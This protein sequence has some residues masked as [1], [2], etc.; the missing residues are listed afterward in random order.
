M[1]ASNGIHPERVIRGGHSTTSNPPSEDG[2]ETQPSE[3]GGPSDAIVQRLA[4]AIKRQLNR[5][6]GV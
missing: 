6:L 5:D 3:A 2:K 1:M 4:D